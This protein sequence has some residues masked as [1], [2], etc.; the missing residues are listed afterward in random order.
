M[1]LW[2]TIYYLHIFENQSELLVDEYERDFA[3]K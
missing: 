2:H 1:S 3:I